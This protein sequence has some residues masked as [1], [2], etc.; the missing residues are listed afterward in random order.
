VRTARVSDDHFDRIFP[1]RLLEFA[2]NGRHVD[3]RFGLMDYGPVDLS[4]EQTKEI[5]VGMQTVGKLGDWLRR[6][7]DGIAAKNS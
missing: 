1:S 4:T 7:E 6:C 3:V 2:A 5:R